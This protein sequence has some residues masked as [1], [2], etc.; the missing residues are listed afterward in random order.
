MH[1]LLDLLHEPIDNTSPQIGLKQRAFQFL[2][3]RWVWPPA[4]QAIKG[5]PEAIT[6]P[7]KPIVQSLKPPHGQWLLFVR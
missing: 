7:T 1:L 4:Q 6:S 2:Q 5:L 3:K